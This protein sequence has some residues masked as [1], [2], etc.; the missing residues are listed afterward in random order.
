MC[1]CVCVCEVVSV[2]GVCKR[3]IKC[4]K[5]ENQELTIFVYRDRGE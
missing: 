2:G 1:M 3:E 5:L 4:L